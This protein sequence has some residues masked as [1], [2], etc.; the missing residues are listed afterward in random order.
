MTPACRA[1]ANRCAPVRC[2]S[3]SHA[4]SRR[5]GSPSE[6]WL[7]CPIPGSVTVPS[8][9]RTV[10][11]CAAAPKTSAP[12]QLD[13]DA[14]EYTPASVGPETIRSCASS[15]IACNSTKVMRRREHRANH[16]AS[17]PRRANWSR[18][19]ILVAAQARIELPQRSRQ[20]DERHRH[21]PQWK[22]PSNRATASRCDV[23]PQAAL[24]PR[25]VLGSAG[26]RAVPADAS[27]RRQAC[28]RASARASI[29]AQMRCC[30]IKSSR[31][32]HSRQHAH[33]RARRS[34]SASVELTYQGSSAE[35]S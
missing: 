31:Q 11:C 10:G 7:A 33:R 32:P 2:C 13:F 30:A 16:F 15:R 12:A 24:H 4:Q 28:N 3:A 26:S 9:K 29:A 17:R 18:C 25:L 21:E 27:A 8:A 35:T 14:S 22:P 23:C 6:S 34:R 19:D 20:Q 5:R 1:R